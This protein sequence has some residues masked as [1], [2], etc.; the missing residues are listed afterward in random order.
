M[1]SSSEAWRQKFLDTTETRIFIGCLEP[2]CL[3]AWTLCE[4]PNTQPQT[5]R[6]G[7]EGSRS[8]VWRYLNPKSMQNTGPKPTIIAIKAIILHLF[9][10]QVNPKP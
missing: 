2:Q 10:V 5:Q 8:G 7:V 6:S 4:G 9:G 3:C 1:G